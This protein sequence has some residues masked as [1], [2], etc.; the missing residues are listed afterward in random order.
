MVKIKFK[1]GPHFEKLLL[2]KYVC[3]TLGLSLKEGKEAVDSGVIECPDHEY[4]NAVKKIAE[5]GGIQ[6]CEQKPLPDNTASVQV[7]MPTKSKK[8]NVPVIRIVPSEYEGGLAI[9]SVIPVD[10]HVFQTLSNHPSIWHSV[11][12]QIPFVCGITQFQNGEDEHYSL[13]AARVPVNHNTIDEITSLSKVVRDV[14]TEII[15]TIYR[16]RNLARKFNPFIDDV[17]VEART[18]SDNLR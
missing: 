11:I 1:E 16:F 2:V 6:I 4:N 3:Q 17:N 9:E 7:S 13:L 12:D 8:E 14:H 10:N 5:C 15:S 18:N